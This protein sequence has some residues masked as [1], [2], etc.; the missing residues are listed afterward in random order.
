MYLQL[1]PLSSLPKTNQEE[2]IEIV[3]PSSSKTKL[4][5]PSQSTLVL[6]YKSL[7]D[8]KGNAV[9]LSK[10]KKKIELLFLWPLPFK[11]EMLQIDFEMGSP[12]NVS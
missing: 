3:F 2:K 1:F 12:A 5:I 10:K 7:L 8:Q 9:L 4:E 11:T 6:F